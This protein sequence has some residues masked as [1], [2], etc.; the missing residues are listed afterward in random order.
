MRVLYMLKKE[1]Y[2]KK[3]EEI[4]KTCF[5]TFCKYGLAET[6]VNRLAEACKMSRG[7]FYNYFK[8]LDDLIIQSTSFCMTKVDE[9]VL[10]KAPTCPEEIDEFLDKIP[11]W[12]CKKYGKK[13]RTMYQI[14][15]HPKYYKEGKKFYEEANKRYQKYAEELEPT[16]KIPSDIIAPLIF[17]FAVA[18]TNY[19]LF[20][21]NYY[22][23]TQMKI[24]NDGIKVYYQNHHVL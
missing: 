3:K 17:V 11:T 7:N 14:Y 20:E 15:T 4:M 8:N 23:E 19:S 9:E 1:N 16:L 21:D 13:Y 12:A 10:K 5:D 24:L 6:S 18:V 22:L 2:N